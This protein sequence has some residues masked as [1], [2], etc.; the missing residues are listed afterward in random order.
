MDRPVADTWAAKMGLAERELVSFVGAGGKTTLMLALAR[1]LADAGHQVVVTTTT[2]MSLDEL[3]PPMVSSRRVLEANLDRRGPLYWAERA[4][5]GKVTGP[6]PGEVN[7]LYADTAVDYVLVEADGAAGHSIKA[8]ADHEPVI[9]SR[10]TVVVVV[11]GVDAIGSTIAAAAH[12][13]ERVAKLLDKSLTHRLSAE[14][15]ARVVTSAAGGLKEV[16]ARARVVVALSKV[17]PDDVDPATRLA[18]IVS[19]NPDVAR[20]IVVP[21]QAAG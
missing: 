16:P 20:A 15:V 13:P 6:S 19:A 3:E 1:E 17:G 11:I 7:G 18:A 8:P 9:P 2:N 21:R 14:D 5:E 10:S 12:R 4:P